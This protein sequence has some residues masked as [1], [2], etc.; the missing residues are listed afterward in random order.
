MKFSAL[1]VKAKM[2][3]GYASVLALLAIISALGLYGMS[4]TNDKLKHVTEVNA[5][6]MAL[7][8]DMSNSVHVVSRVIR[9]LA[10]ISDQATYDHEFAKIG[11]AREEYNK[12]FDDLKKMPLDQKGLD[13]VAEIERDMNDARPKNNHFLELAKQDKQAGVDFLLKVANPA[14]GMWQDHIHQFINLQREKNKNDELAAAE[15]Y[16]NLRSLILLL[17]FAAIGCAAIIGTLITR[18][19]LRQLGAE[20]SYVNKVA[21][22]IATGDLTVEIDVSKAQTNS[23]IYAI[24]TMRDNFADIVGKVAR[25]AET[26]ANASAEISTGNME[27]SSRSEL[28][29]SSLEETASSME[30]LTSTVKQNAE[31]SL[32]ANQLASTASEVAGKGGKMVGDVIAT[33]GAINDSSKKIVDIISV[34]DG[35]AFQTN[36]LALNA[37]VEAARAGEQGR[38]FAVVA[39]EVRNLAQRSAT[40]AKE[41]K[42]LISDT[43]E[44]VANGAKMVDEA[45]ATIQEVVIS[46]QRVSA[47]ISE[48]TNASQEQTAG[49]DQIHMAVAQID[50][51]TQQN[52]ALVEE[53]AAASQSLNEQ[54]AELEKLVHSFKINHDLDKNP[55]SQ[56]PLKLKKAA[57]IKPASTPNQRKLK[58]VPA[59]PPKK[60]EKMANTD[61]DWVEF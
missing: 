27:L 11:A 37:A 33:M 29:A 49:I 34:I 52:A 53:A 6:K 19:L 40:A 25:G 36:I 7:L 14:T 21:A 61:K 60:R 47:V 55:K 45:G 9:S 28:Q 57:A 41:I 16:A 20:P 51:T 42:T 38:G 30:E 8:E 58:M 23:L 5:V 59:L 4:V 15:A 18:S 3:T 31:N 44:K 12:A 48:I 35:I 50:E 13:F 56:Q 10:L 26:I 2:I 24:K 43:V 1:T 32:Q 46:V 54:A 17:A 39:S 22:Q